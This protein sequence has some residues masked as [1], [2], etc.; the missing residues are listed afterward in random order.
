VL[1][2]RVI[3][4]SLESADSPKVKNAERLEFREL[5]EGFYTLKARFGFMETP[6]VPKVMDL[7]AKKGVELNL[8]D[9]TFFLGRETLLT[10][11]T[12][13]MAKWRKYLFA[14]L[15]KNA[16]NATT[17]FGLPPGRVVEL[18]SQVVL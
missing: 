12:S 15:A 13:K 9:T 1:H 18:G 11:G 8:M 4:L 7:L 17:F 5:S 2:E 6:N 10:T 14:F 16:W 3:L